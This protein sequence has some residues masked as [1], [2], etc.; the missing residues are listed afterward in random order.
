MLTKKELSEQLASF[1]PACA[2]D[3]VVSFFFTYKV[4]FTISKSRK[5]KHGDY[6]APHNGLPHQISVNGSLN[7]YHFLITTLHEFAHL[8]TYENFGNSVS[9]HG[10]EWRSTFKSLLAP[11]LKMDDIPYTIRLA[12]SEE[13]NHLKAS[14]S[15]NAKLYKA[16]NQYNIK[17]S[18]LQY[19]SDIP[20][21]KLF[22][23]QGKTFKKLELRRTRYLCKEINTN[24]SYLIPK[25]AQVQIIEKQD[26]NGK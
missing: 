11:L 1:L 9:A 21:E 4:K 22:V 23:L 18:D 24:R 15:G 19:L 3:Y 16:L 17:D 8:I 2:V 26:S 20:M 14:T 10:K 13:I 7:E 6:R 25:I 12:L 5:T